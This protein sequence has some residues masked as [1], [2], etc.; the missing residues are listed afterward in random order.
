MRECLIRLCGALIATTIL[1]GC[2]PTDV[3]P[4]PA[5]TAVPTERPTDVPT[6]TPWDQIP[7]SV[8]AARDAA[9]FYV[10]MTY[11][12][13]APPQDLDWNGERIIREGLIGS[14]S[15]RFA[16]GEWTMEINV[17]IVVPENVTCRVV[18]SRASTG[19]LWQGEVGAAG[20]VTESSESDGANR[21]AGWY[22]RV[23]GTPDG[24][25]YDD[26]LV[27][28]PEGTGEMGLEGLSQAIGD[29]IAN[30]R[31]SDAAAHFW[32][33]L[34]TDVPDYGGH[35]LRVE[36]VRPEGA[37][38]LVDSVVAGWEG[39]VVSTPSGAQFDDYLQL[40]GDFPVRYGIESSAPNAA[41]DV[42]LVRDSLTPIRVWGTLTC[43]VPD[44]NGCQLDVARLVLAGEPLA[45]TP[46]PHPSDAQGEPVDGW[47]GTIVDLPPGNQFGQY[48]ELEGGDEFGVATPTDSIRELV[49]EAASTGARIMVWGK[50]YTGVPAGEVRTIEIERLEFLSH[51]EG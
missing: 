1:V 21:I 5:P 47:V 44:V 14:S 46:T 50:L 37:G 48:F 41:S 25:Q 43:G 32:G 13:E 28:L 26:Y 40:A 31:D 38:P 19:F 39:I 18:L 49:R 24:S 16:G 30:L 8:R 7:A 2:A 42:E 51:P 29:E 33:A 11:G 36:R 17:P 10:R 3:E 15:F 23:V 45:P 34:V 4:T 27:L 12:E 9:L 6:V 35:Q 20:E 22:G